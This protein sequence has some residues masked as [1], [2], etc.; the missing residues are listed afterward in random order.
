M[1]KKRA[2]HINS[3]VYPKVDGGKQRGGFEGSRQP[4]SDRQV[5]ILDGRARVAK[6][7]VAKH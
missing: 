2:K 1:T 7:V 4:P 6:P 5:L 3:K